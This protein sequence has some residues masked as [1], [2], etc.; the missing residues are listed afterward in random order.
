[1]RERWNALS[2]YVT[3]ATAFLIVVFQ[4]RP[5]SRLGSHFLNCLTVFLVLYLICI[6]WHRLVNIQI[7]YLNT[8][9]GSI[10]IF[11][12]MICL[13]G[14]VVFYSGSLE[15]TLKWLFVIPITLSSYRYGFKLSI[16]LTLIVALTLSFNYLIEHQVDDYYDPLIVDI[17][18]I[19]ILTSSSFVISKTKSVRTS[20]FTPLDINQSKILFLEE[21]L[22][23][24]PSFLRESNQTY[25]TK[26][27]T[28]SRPDICLRILNEKD[29]YA[30]S[31]SHRVAVNC[32]LIAEKMEIN[33]EIIS[34]L[35]TA[36]TYHDIG[37]VEISPLVLSKKTPLTTSETHLVS[38][39]P[40]WGAE[41]MNDGMVDESVVQGIIMHHE[42]MD[43]TGYPIGLTGEQIPIIPRI[44]AVADTID[45]MASLRPFSSAKSVYEICEELKHHSG[46]KLDVQVCEAAITLIKNEILVMP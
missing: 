10:V 9:A 35:L 45:S 20:M 17:L 41:I 33:Q 7:E 29:R 37:M 23:I 26:K 43:G 5:L 13:I 34:H 28:G 38:R 36:A 14:A 18:T 15:S 42:R 40:E 8:N 32:R 19:L 12:A 24:P 11:S 31:H 21:A 6:F 1:V 16:I 3:F 4:L 30:L 22:P 46:L 44:I 27:D 2:T 39:H 25:T